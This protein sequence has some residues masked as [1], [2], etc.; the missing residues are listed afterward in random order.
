MSDLGDG[1]NPTYALA[2]LLA[3]EKLDLAGGTGDGE[4]VP[5]QRGRLLVM[6]GDQVYPRRPTSRATAITAGGGGAFLSDSHHR[7]EHLLLPPP[8]SP[9]TGKRSKA[10]ASFDLKACRPTRRSRAVSPSAR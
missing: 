3:E 2:T 10:P 8:D 7:P 6:G 4:S 5:T 1:F 9:H